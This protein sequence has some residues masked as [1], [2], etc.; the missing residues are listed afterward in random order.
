MIHSLPFALFGEGKEMNI[1]LP[2]VLKMSYQRTHLRRRLQLAAFRTD[3]H[4]ALF[5]GAVSDVRSELKQ[6]NHNAISQQT[7][8]GFLET[9]GAGF[10]RGHVDNHLPEALRL[11]AAQIPFSFPYASQFGRPV[12]YN[13]QAGTEQRLLGSTLQVS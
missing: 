12:E 5:G 4:N 9:Q 10:E 11:F 13:V 8:P 2:Q 3:K 7:P 6:S 1:F